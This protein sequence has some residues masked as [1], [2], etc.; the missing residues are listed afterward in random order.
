M[1]KFDV[2]N[3]ETGD[4]KVIDVSVHE[5]QQWYEDNKPWVRDWSQGCA[6][7]GDI[8]EWKDTLIKKNPGWNDV[9][10][11]AAKAPGSYVEKI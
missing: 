11:Q 1:A 5:I 3:T 7:G 10:G 4:T 9:L 6:S 2:V 8:G